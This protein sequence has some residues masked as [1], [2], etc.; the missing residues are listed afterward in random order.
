LTEEAIELHK[1][2]LKT[3]LEIEEKLLIGFSEKEKNNLFD[4]LLR[5]ECNLENKE[6][7]L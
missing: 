4:Y 6:G 5:I 3:F 2:V 7:E 1:K